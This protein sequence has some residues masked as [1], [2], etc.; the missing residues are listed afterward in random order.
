MELVIAS[1]RQVPREQ[2]KRTLA[3]L[4]EDRSFS[5][6]RSDIGLLQSFWMASRRVVQLLDPAYREP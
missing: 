1:T 4:I 3:R 5:L 6:Q 2:R